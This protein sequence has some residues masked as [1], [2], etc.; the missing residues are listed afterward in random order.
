MKKILLLYRML[1]VAALVLPVASCTKNMS[2]PVIVCRITGILENRNGSANSFD[3]RYNSHGLP[4]MITYNSGA[5]TLTRKITYFNKLVVSALRYSSGDLI[6]GDSV[7]YNSNN[8][9]AEIKESFDSFGSDW[10]DT[11]FLYDA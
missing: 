9:I 3:I 6:V 8:G 10:N 1:F 4:D 5:A 2:S 7:W 11:K